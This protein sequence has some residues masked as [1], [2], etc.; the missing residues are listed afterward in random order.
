MRARVN[1][2]ELADILRKRICPVC[3][4]Q[5]AG[6]TCETLEQN[7]CRLFQL[8]PLVAQAILATESEELEPYLRAIEENVCAVCIDQSLDGTCARRGHGCAL[9]GR[10]PEI[11]AA[12][13]E[14]AGRSFDAKP[15][16]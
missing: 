5:N 10:L 13:E 7:E 14:A 2:E 9:D 6:G 4:G 8:F 11:V 3:G 12:I 1:F 16:P 15:R